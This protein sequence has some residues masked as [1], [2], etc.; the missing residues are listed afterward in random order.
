MTIRDHLRKRKARYLWI[1]VAC[2]VTA[3]ALIVT[4]EITDRNIYSHMALA[5]L[6]AYMACIVLS[7]S[8]A[9]P[10]CRSAVGGYTSWLNLRT[11]AVVR[12]INFCAHCG[13]DFDAPVARA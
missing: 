12:R 6:L 8:I 11:N 10:R 4:Y 9:C 13:V 3:F 1:G 2:L 7:P 5:L